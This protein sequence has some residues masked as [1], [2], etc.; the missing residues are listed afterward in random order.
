MEDSMSESPEAPIEN[1]IDWEQEFERRHAQDLRFKRSGANNLERAKANQ[2]LMEG[3]VNIGYILG[4]MVTMIAVFNFVIYASPEFNETFERVDF[5]KITD[6]TPS[7]FL[8]ICGSSCEATRNF[9]NQTI[10]DFLRQESN[11]SCYQEKG[12]CFDP[13]VVYS[14]SSG[15]RFE[16][17]SDRRGNITFHENATSPFLNCPDWE[18]E[19]RSCIDAYVVRIVDNR[20]FC[21]GRGGTLTFSGQEYSLVDILAKNIFN[22]YSSVYA[23]LKSIAYGFLGY[24]FYGLLKFFFCG[25]DIGFSMVQTTTR[26][27]FPQ[28]AIG[29]NKIVWKLYG[30]IDLHELVKDCMLSCSW[31][32]CALTLVYPEYFYV[33]QAGVHSKPYDTIQFHN[34]GWSFFEFGPFIAVPDYTIFISQCGENI[35]NRLF[36]KASLHGF[37]GCR[38][39]MLFSP[40]ILGP[41]LVH[42]VTFLPIMISNRCLGLQAHYLLSWD[43]ILYLLGNNDLCL[44]TGTL[45]IFGPRHHR[46]KKTTLVRHR[47]DDI[48]GEWSIDEHSESE[49]DPSSFYSFRFVD[50]LGHEDVIGGEKTTEETKGET[51]APSAVNTS[52]KNPLAV[53][54]LETKC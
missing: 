18:T 50:N 47:V 5:N 10:G 53:S 14:F 49:E 34:F 44:I 38:D 41:L 11:F 28:I 9:S 17:Y 21:K 43:E 15:C 39:K 2:V 48:V 25:Y 42:I 16:S 33:T 46:R 26:S 27:S 3:L 12:G 29:V 37:L 45:R 54:L 7:N 1:I 32:I 23:S 24:Q 36:P 20:T 35:G 40:L 8:Q 22:Y 13:R 19:I 31:A 52:V 4:I 6:T 30:V 51:K